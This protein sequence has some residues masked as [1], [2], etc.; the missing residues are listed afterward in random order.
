MGVT[1]LVMAGGK[2]TR[3]GSSIEKPLLEVCGKTLLERVVTA[4]RRSK[5]VE[6]IIVVVTAASSAT[7]MKARALGLETI[8]TA[9]LGYEAD[10]SSA[11]TKLGL[12]DVLVV[13]ADL[14]FLTETLVD[15]SV[16]RYVESRK[17]ALSVMCPTG[18]YEKV[19]TTPSY[20][21]VID[22]RKLAP[23]GIN[24]ING[25]RVHEGELEQEVLVVD[26]ELIALN[27]NSP[28]E[29]ELAQSRCK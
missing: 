9:G 6:R 1:A 28:H 7:S 5:A 24:L 11:I 25:K 23:V 26:S 21:F 13:S 18:A 3:M 14:P 8:E 17:P 4:L 27:V 22:G 15:E 12:G 10:M 19:G 16:R 29:L 2:G 20:V